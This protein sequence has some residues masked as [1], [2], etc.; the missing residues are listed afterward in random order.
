MVSRDASC[1]CFRDVIQEYARD[2]TNIRGRS[3]RATRTSIQ[4]EVQKFGRWC[5]SICI[6]MA[7]VVFF[8]TLKTIHRTPTKEGC[9]AVVTAP[10]QHTFAVPSHASVLTMIHDCIKNIL[11]LLPRTFFC[12]CANGGLRLASLGRRAFEKNKQFDVVALI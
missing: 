8:V 10:H 3:R 12:I 1:A 11:F 7:A 5:I 4:N 9:I 6:V 2:N